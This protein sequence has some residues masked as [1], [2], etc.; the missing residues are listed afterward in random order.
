MDK[1]VSKDTLSPG[2]TLAT[3]S[4]NCDTKKGVHP[5]QLGRFSL[6]FVLEA[7]RSRTSPFHLVFLTHRLELSEYLAGKA[8]VGV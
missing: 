4:Y 1:R 6:G 5:L 7:A 2:P 3:Y 8:E